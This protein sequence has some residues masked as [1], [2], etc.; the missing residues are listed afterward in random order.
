MTTLRTLSVA[1]IV[2]MTTVVGAAAS[3]DHSRIHLPAVDVQQKS[4]GCDFS[5]FRTGSEDLNL[6]QS[7]DGGNIGHRVHANRYFPNYS[8]IGD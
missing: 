8:P 3:M 5:G 7:C 6:D 1:G 4:S 2:L